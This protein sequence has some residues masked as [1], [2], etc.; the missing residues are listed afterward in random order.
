LRL[1]LHSYFRC[2]CCCFGIIGW[3]SGLQCLL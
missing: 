1:V 3:I 2:C